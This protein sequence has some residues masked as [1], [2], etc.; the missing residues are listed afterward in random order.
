MDLEND[1]QEKREKRAEA[2]KA[3]PESVGQGCKPAAR[4]EGLKLRGLRPLQKD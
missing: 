3:G 1:W 4:V 2:E